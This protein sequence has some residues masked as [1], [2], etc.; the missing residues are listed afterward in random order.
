MQTYEGSLSILSF[1]R[2]P[3]LSY[4]HLTRVSI[5]GSY[6]ISVHASPREDHWEATLRVVRYLKGN[7]G[8]GILLHS[9][10]DFTLE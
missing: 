7:P 5:F 1:G 3:H 2:M 6:F 8:P 9:D 10:S 4:C